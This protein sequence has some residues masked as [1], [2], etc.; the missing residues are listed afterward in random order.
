MPFL[1]NGRP[2]M[3]DDFIPQPD[4]HPVITYDSLNGSGVEFQFSLAEDFRAPIGDYWIYSTMTNSFTVS[5]SSGE[6]DI[7]S[8]QAFGIGETVHYRYRTIDSTAKIS[9]WTSGSFLLPGY[10]VTNN[11]DG[12]ATLNI[13]NND[14]NLDGYEL[15]ENTYVTSSN[16]TQQANSPFLILENDP[17]HQTIVHLGLNLHLLGLPSNLT[18]LDASVELT[19]IGTIGSP[20]MLSMHEYN[21]DDWLE[22]EATW[23]YG[24]VGNTWSN[25]GLDAIN[26]AEDTDINSLQFS[27]TFAIS[28]HDS[29]Q[30]QIGESVSSRVNYVLTG[31]LPGEQNPAQ[32]DGIIFAA[33]IGPDVTSWPTLNLTYSLP[34][35]TSTAEAKLLNPINGQ[36]T[37]N[38]TGSNLSGNTTP[39]MTWETS[40]NTQKHSII[41]VSTDEFFR[42]KILE[43]DSKAA[44]DIPGTSDSLTIQATDSLTTGNMYYWRVKHVDNDGRGGLWNETSFFVTSVSSQ[45]LGGD[46]YK[47]SINNSVD[48]G[49]ADIPNFPFS[50]IS[51]N[52]PNVNSYGYP[53]LSWHNRPQVNPMFCLGLM[54]W[55][56]YYRTA[57][58]LLNL[59]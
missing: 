25:G 5:G 27:D 40:D 8:S 14:L 30:Q 38:V 31:M 37:W 7:P 39:I 50:T 19:R 59:N 11:N 36:T 21:G 56:I 23:N 6:Y 57:W 43:Y 4:I 3:T 20:M 41:Q 52:S 17:S 42:H 15:I 45:W 58:L 1:T 9:Q 18:I 24:R 2:L 29:A 26:S 51:S 53:F 49:F 22:D 47:L 32:L 54:R 34:V 33:D 12:T 48:Q 13:S 28:V 35:N 10:S 44:N 55:I 46:V 16:P